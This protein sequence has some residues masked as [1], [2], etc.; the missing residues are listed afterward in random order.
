MWKSITINFQFNSKDKMNMMNMMTRK[1]WIKYR[2]RIWLCKR[3]KSVSIRTNSY[4]EKTNKNESIITIELENS[5]G[6][7]KII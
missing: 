3:M 2:C 5:S 6:N 1:N 7:K 4:F